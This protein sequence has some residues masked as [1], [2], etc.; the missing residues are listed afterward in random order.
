MRRS[1][2]SWCALLAVLALSL[3]LPL[4]A[5]AAAPSAGHAMATFECAGKRLTSGAWFCHPQP[6]WASTHGNTQPAHPV[7][8]CRP[9]SCPPHC[10]SKTHLQDFVLQ[11]RS[12]T[13][14]DRLTRVSSPKP[15]LRRDQLSARAKQTGQ[16]LSPLAC[17]PQRPLSNARL[18]LWRREAPAQAQLGLVGNRAGQ[19]PWFSS[20][21]TPLRLGSPPLS[22]TV[23]TVGAAEELEDYDIADGGKYIVTVKSNDVLQPTVDDFIKQFGFTPERIFSSLGM[24]SSAL[25]LEQVSRFLYCCH[26]LRPGCTRSYR[27]TVLV[28]P[29]G[30]WRE[31]DVDGKARS[32]ATPHSTN[33]AWGAG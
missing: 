2:L 9:A 22:V 6:E 31:N 21:W 15:P 10:R 16:V 12:P 5:A 30:R 1:R 19:R 20:A 33:Y 32:S 14:R 27:R 11:G 4:F 23:T 17:C 29:V 24:F 18:R 28:A 8:H 7:P 26:C 13:P 3:S 25:N